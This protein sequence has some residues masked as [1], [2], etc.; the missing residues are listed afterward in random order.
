MQLASASATQ[1]VLHTQ[2]IYAFVL[3]NLH[4]G[5]LTGKWHCIGSML[6]AKPDTWQ[7]TTISGF[8]GNN[9]IHLT[10]NFT[11][12]IPSKKRILI[13][14]DT[15][16]QQ[17]FQNKSHLHGI[18]LDNID[19]TST[20][21]KEKLVS[22]AEFLKPWRIVL[23]E[24]NRFFRF[25]T[26]LYSYFNVSF[27]GSEYNCSIRSLL[28]LECFGRYRSNS[29]IF[30]RRRFSII[31][32]YFLRMFASRNKL[33]RTLTLSVGRHEQSIFREMRPLKNE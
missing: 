15:W 26:K 22:Y 14:M 29:R 32:K 7:L 2:C 5:R 18:S 25:V 31:L 12:I 24:P 11:T 3:V 21:Q 1:Y 20:W 16:F 17:E 10:R 6:T 9:L 28:F 19:I 23:L 8:L 27:I 30:V 13:Y 4:H 33:V